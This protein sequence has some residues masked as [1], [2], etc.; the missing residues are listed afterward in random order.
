MAEFIE[1]RIRTWLV[2]AD[3]GLIF[4]D[5]IQ[6]RAA[7]FISVGSWSKSLAWKFSTP[8][9]EENPFEAFQEAEKPAFRVTAE[10]SLAKRPM[11][12]SDAVAA[13]FN[14]QITLDIWDMEQYRIANIVC[15]NA[16]G[17]KAQVRLVLDQLTQMDP[18][19]KVDIKKSLP[20]FSIPE[21]A[22]RRTP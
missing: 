22:G 3:I 2:T 4:R 16:P 13:S 1:H 17:P 20:G 14:G 9:Q 18:A 8:A 12:Y 21:K 15:K 19:A 7:G 11:R 5:Y 6:G 10:H